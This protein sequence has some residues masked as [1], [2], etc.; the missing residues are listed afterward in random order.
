M[1]ITER[2]MVK[3]LLCEDDCLGLFLTHNLAFHIVQL[4]LLVMQSYFPVLLFDQCYCSISHSHIYSS[5]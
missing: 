1:E 2:S 5:I 3:K 4:C